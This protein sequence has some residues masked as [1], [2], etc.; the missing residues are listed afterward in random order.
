MQK[1]LQVSITIFATLF[2]H[3]HA[4]QRVSVKTAM[5]SEVAIY[6][7]R[8]A[9][10]TVVSLNESV[11]SARILARVDELS[12]RV[13][14]IVE[15]G[16]ILAKLDCSDYE[17]AYREAVAKLEAQ[18][19]RRDFAKRKLERTH[20]LFTKQS[21]SEAILDER[22]SSYAVSG[23]DLKGMQAEINMKKLD[24]SRCTVTSPF[25]ALVVE[26]ASAVGEFV[27]VGKA[28]VKI[29]D[30]DN[31]EISAQVLDRDAMQL[32]KTS[33]LFFEHG[34]VRYPV[35]LRSILGV[36]N[37]ETRNRESRLIFTDTYA[38]PGTTGKLVWRDNQAHI[39]GDLLVWRNGKLGVFT[40]EKN[41]AQFNVMPSAQAGR[42]SATELAD[43]VRVVIEGHYSLT[44]AI[45]V[46]IV[47]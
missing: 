22:E 29:I 13:G 47:N 2:V 5:L 30:I 23:H 37:A 27:D 42:A 18:K 44:E 21:V 41:I 19:I 43:N 25:R 4:A 26:R 20:Q 15:K 1:L 14:D 39:P 17:F 46:D 12:V 10:A 6:S 9:P 3:A 34:G 11:I 33:T 16:G 35:K 31:A 8:S 32:S 38:L 36:I 28:L 45:P 7:E 40:V 24:R